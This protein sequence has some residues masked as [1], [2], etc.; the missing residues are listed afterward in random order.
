MT[1]KLIADKDLWDDFVNK[2][3]Y[4]LLFHRWDL[5]KTIEK[6]SS[7]QLLT[8]GIYSGEELICVFPLFVRNFLGF[9]M[10]FSPPPWSAISYMGPVMSPLYD[11]VKPRKKEQYMAAVADEISK[12]IDELAPIYVSFY[13][14][15][16][17]VDVRGFKWNGFRAD[18]MYTYVIQLDRPVEVIWNDMDK[19]CKQTINA[20]AKHEGLAVKEMW[21]IESY[22]SVVKNRYQEQ[23]IN[24]PLISKEYLKE[25]TCLYPESVRSYLLYKADDLLN[26]LILY[27]TKKRATLWLGAINLD[28]KI[29]SLEYLIW[30]IIKIKK[31][32]G[33]TELEIEGANTRRLCVF[34]A[35]FN[36][37]L[38]PAFHV[39]KI[40][41]KG[42]IAELMYAN[43]IKKRWFRK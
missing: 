12:V 40:D 36:P 21:D 37:D 2:S 16:G 3:P 28:R 14:V 42:R 1:A 41:R 38:E 31:Q 30:E 33:L 18:V 39:S 43:M 6:H 24:L 9:K 15:P 22:H 7:Y 32:Q 26:I 25:I 34:K 35:K 4:G 11:T 17:L 10:V 29:D 20:T 23:G 8:Y 5:L 13:F 19:H 27:E